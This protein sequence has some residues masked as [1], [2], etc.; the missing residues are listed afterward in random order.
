MATLYL[1]CFLA[2]LTALFALQNATPVTVRL[3]F[4]Q[5]DSSL[6]LVILASATLGFFMA[7]FLAIAPVWRRTRRF[8][9][10][11][12][13]VV[14]QGARIRGLEGELRSTEPTRERPEPTNGPLLYVRPGSS[15]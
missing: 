8:Q 10:L 4:W 3:L 9:Y 13:T 1:A 12:T 14:S 11:S 7:F 5:Q 6:V 2:L 15:P